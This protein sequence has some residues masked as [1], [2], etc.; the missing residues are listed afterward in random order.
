MVCVRY[1]GRENDSGGLNYNMSVFRRFG[2]TYF[3]AKMDKNSKALVTA[4]LHRAY[5]DATHDVALHAAI[6]NLYFP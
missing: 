3:Y 1:C 5:D 6:F 4:T 2:I